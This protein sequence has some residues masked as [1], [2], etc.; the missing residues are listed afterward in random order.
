LLRIVSGGAL[1]L[2]GQGAQAVPAA[3]RQ[4]LDSYQT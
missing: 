2:L 4:W 1:R 3:I